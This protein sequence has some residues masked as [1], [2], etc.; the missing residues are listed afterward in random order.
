VCCCTACHIS[1]NSLLWCKPVLDMISMNVEPWL[2]S[3][4]LLHLQTIF[5]KLK[6]FHCIAFFSRVSF[7][8]GNFSLSTFPVRI[9]LRLFLIQ[10]NIMVLWCQHQVLQSVD[11]ISTWVIFRQKHILFLLPMAVLSLYAIFVIFP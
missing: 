9:F 7:F 4:P 10:I 5:W 2:I 6:Y 8:H 11:K 1:R 3:F